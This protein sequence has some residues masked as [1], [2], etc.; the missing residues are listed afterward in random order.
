MK[1]MKNDVISEA[2]IETVPPESVMTEPIV[3]KEIDLE[4]CTVGTCDFST[5]FSLKATKTA[6]LTCLVGYF[7]TFFDLPNSVQFSTGPQSTKTHWQQT[8]FFLKDTIQMNK[9]KKKVVLSSCESFV[10][11]DVIEGSLTCS[12]LTKNIRGL[13]VT[14]V[15]GKNKYSYVLD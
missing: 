5:S 4:T 13:S 9:G 15:L 8:V 3:L 2:V 6:L 11:G 14:V 7:D 12:R 1:C 10:P